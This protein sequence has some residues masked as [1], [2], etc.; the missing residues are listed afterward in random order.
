M[1]VARSAV[2]LAALRPLWEELTKLSPKTCF[3]GFTWNLL[4]AELFADRATPL[5]M[6]VESDSG[7]A[8]IPACVNL[9]ANR[10]ELLGEALFDYRDVLRVGEGDALRAAWQ[11]L[12]DCNLPVSVTAVQPEAKQSS[13]ADFTVHEFARAPWVDASQV[14]ENEFRAAHPRVGSRLRKIERKG[15]SLREYCGIARDMVT[16][17][18]QLKCD[19][20]A[21]DA[22]N[23]FR[24]QVRRQ[25]MVEIAAAEG[26]NCSVFTLEDQAAG[27]IAGLVTFLDGPIR[28]FYTIYFDPKWAAYSPGVALMFE[29]TARSLAEGISCD[30]MT[31]EYPY[32]LRFAN[33][34]RMLYRVEASA[35]ELGEIARADAERRVA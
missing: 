35:E 4:A 13:W 2:E 26:D 18:Y 30:Y 29:A 1:I 33:A 15:V 34:S 10:I 21:G 5:A 25:F 28:R 23:I 6:A 32:K 17:L 11:R 24:D 20:F 12:A 31:G 8:I 9:G 14:S 7:A 22:N 16:R 3:Q 19:Q 27:I